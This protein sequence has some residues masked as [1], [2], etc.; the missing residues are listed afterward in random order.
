MT[1]QPVTPHLTLYIGFPTRNRHVP[2]AFVNKLETRLRLGGVAYQVATGSVFK[3]PRGKIPYVDL[4][5]E[6]ASREQLADS[7]F[8][9]RRLVEDGLMGGLNEGL[10]PAE[11]ARDLGVRALLEDKLYFYQVRI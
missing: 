8:I 11:R 7:T 6:G 3:A 10:T 1:T 5:A 9:T 4:H 2:S